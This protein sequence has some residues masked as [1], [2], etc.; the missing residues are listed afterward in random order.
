MH[1]STSDEDDNGTPDANEYQDVNPF[2]TPI[3]PA[4]E[5]LDLTYQPAT[6]TEVDLNAIHSKAMMLSATGIALGIA[7][8]VAIALGLFIITPILALGIIAWAFPAVRHFRQHARHMS[9]APRVGLGLLLLFH[10]TLILASTVGLL[11]F[12]TCIAIFSAAGN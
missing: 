10:G 1:E 12:A 2:V 9:V 11:F 8:V 3:D 4:E 7:L 5:E 6:E